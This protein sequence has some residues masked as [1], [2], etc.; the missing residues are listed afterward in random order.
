MADRGYGADP[1]REELAL[2]GFRLLARRG[3]NRKK[4]PANDGR[5]L[6]RYERRWAVE[7]AFAWVRSSRRV[8]A[9]Y[10]YLPHLYDGFV[11]LAWV[12]IAPS[13]L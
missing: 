5:R 7:R 4:P 10:E 8:A 6:R 12:S 9:R 11:A 3:K 2:G 1:L 13:K